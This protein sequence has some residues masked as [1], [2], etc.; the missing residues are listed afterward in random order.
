MSSKNTDQLELELAEPSLE[1]DLSW[2]PNSKYP[3]NL[4]NVGRTVYQEIY[5]DIKNSRNVLIVTGF[6]SLSRLIDTFGKEIDCDK[7]GKKVRVIL[8][9]EPNISRRKTYGRRFLSDEIKD[10]WLKQ[11]YSLFRCGNLF[12]IIELVKKG[13]IEFRLFENKSNNLHAKIYVMDDFVTLGSAN[14]SQKGMYSQFEAN[15]RYCRINEPDEYQSIKIIAENYYSLGCDYNSGMLSLLEQLCYATTWKE[16]LAR[17][18]VELL[19]GKWFEELPD[20]YDSVNNINLW[21]FQRQSVAQAFYVLKNNGSVLVANPTGSGKTR[22]I[23]TLQKLMIHHLWETGRRN[24]SYSVTIAPPLVKESWLQEATD[25]R[26]CS[27]EFISMG[28]LSHKAD[29]SHDRVTQQIKQANILAVDEIHNFLDPHSHR[30]Q[31]LEKHDADYLIA[32]TATPI[33]K[34]VQDLFR[35]VVLMDVNNLKDE[36]ISSIKELKR[37]FSKSKSTITDEDYQQLQSFVRKYMVRFTKNQITNLITQEPELYADKNG[38]LC[39]YPKVRHK[40]F[41]VQASELDKSLAR[42]IK[43]KSKSLKGICFL[44]DVDLECGIASH[45]LDFRMILAKALAGYNIMSN[46]RSSKAALVEHIEGTESALKFFGLK[47]RKKHTGNMIEKLH[48]YKNN[49]PN[50]SHCKEGFPEWMIN[51]SEYQKACDEEISTYH[52]ISNITKELSDDREFS[53]VKRLAECF[54]D[55]DLVIAF[56]EKLITLDYLKERILKVKDYSLIAVNII[57]GNSAKDSLMKKFSLGS[58]FKKNLGLLSDCMSEGVGLEQASAVVLLDPPSV[59]RVAEQRIGRIDRLTSPH[60]QVD[61]YWPL[62]DVEFSL[63]KDSRLVQTLEDA[64]STIGCNIKLPEEYYKKLNIKRMIKE[65]TDDAKKDDFLWEGLKDAFAP[66]RELY[67][68]PHNL[69]DYQDY[70]DFKNVKATVKTK[71][72]ISHVKSSEKWLFLSTAGD[73]E[74][75][76]RWLFIDSNGVLYTEL[77]EICVLLRENLSPSCDGQEEKWSQGAERELANFQKILINGQKK[78]LSYKKQRVLVVSELLLKMQK[79]NKDLCRKLKVFFNPLLMGE[80]SDVDF[81]LFSQMWFDLLKE[82][83]ANFKKKNVKSIVSLNDFLKDGDLHQFQ[84]SDLLKMI[85]NIPEIK[86][87]SKRIAA[88]I[89]GIPCVQ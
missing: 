9:F 82:P 40:T 4:K 46:L 10:Y 42:K 77:E 63:N 13:N 55:H 21:P 79:S 61:A 51:I 43:R 25:I 22:V 56:D 65:Y 87:L 70:L 41:S 36:D 27:N 75:P 81:D 58:K 29:K 31:E 19:E 39:K 44:Q 88:C 14:F 3:L 38:R 33:N 28:A 49:L 59:L 1:E 64:E 54:N 30:S 53:K 89:I 57:T 60:K 80:D 67:E 8:G 84:R 47:S 34:K 17:S 74:A 6:S 50:T 66:V 45:T 15:K 76:P 26:F 16:V 68:G 52:E 69:I 73:K 86:P 37:K 20:F 24:D 23:S 35:C 11:G 78:L 71:L 5:I 85:D 72:R 7:E 83:F 48:L 32:G 2:P 12:K 62:D 18:I